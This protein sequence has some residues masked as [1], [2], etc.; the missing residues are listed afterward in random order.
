M[1]KVQYYAPK[2]PP[3]NRRLDAYT[4]ALCGGIQLLRRASDSSLT[5]D[6]PVYRGIISDPT[7]RRKLINRE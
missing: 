7:A 3:R 1:A 5:R 6:A 2:S 4:P